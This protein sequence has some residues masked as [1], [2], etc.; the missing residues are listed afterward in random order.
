MSRLLRDI[1]AVARLPSL[2]Q[3]VEDEALTGWIVVGSVGGIALN[4]GAIVQAACHGW[5]GKPALLELFLEPEGPLFIE[6]WQNVPGEPLGST[7]QLLAEG[8][9]WG[10]VWARL[11]ESCPVLCRP[12]PA[13]PAG[14]T[15]GLL[16]G[17]QTTAQIAACLGARRVALAEALLGLADAGVVRFQAPSPVPAPRPVDYHTAMDLGRV[18]MMAADYDA[19]VGF[20]LRALDARPGDRLARVQLR[21]A[22]EKSA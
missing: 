22:R 9:R 6:H 16:D 5:T 21:R 8:R 11:G 3:R 17:R 1:H 18:R 19:A 12:S 13:L 20:F 2:L 15:A 10:E 14:L 4:E 7:P